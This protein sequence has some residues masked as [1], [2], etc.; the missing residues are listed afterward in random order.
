MSSTS[1]GIFLLCFSLGMEQ[2]TGKKEKANQFFVVEDK[3]WSVTGQKEVGSFE[4][5]KEQLIV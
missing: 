3:N 4:E 2:L 5:G 1:L